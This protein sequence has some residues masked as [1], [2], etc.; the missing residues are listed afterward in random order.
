MLP[1]IHWFHTLL[2][3]SGTWFTTNT[4]YLIQ[5]S[6]YFMSSP[7]QDFTLQEQLTYVRWKFAVTYLIL[8][9]ICTKKYFAN[10]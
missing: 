6:L 5:L 9:P 10:D 1:L 2:K 4:F 3:S 7:F 8:K